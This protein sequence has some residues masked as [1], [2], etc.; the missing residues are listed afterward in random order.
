MQ[1][2]A[3]GTLDSL[4]TD[5]CSMSLDCSSVKLSSDKLMK[6]AGQVISDKEVEAVLSGLHIK[7]KKID[8]TW[9]CTIPT[10][11]TDLLTETDLIEEVFRCYGYDKIEPSFSFTSNMQYAN[12]EE[13]PITSLKNYLSSIGFNQ[14]YNNSLED[15]EDVKLFGKS[16]T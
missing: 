11:R 14:S 10:F 12:D 5:E 8:N 9:D 4:I 15:L 3:G 13:V 1:E 7:A 16:S 2:V 6:Y